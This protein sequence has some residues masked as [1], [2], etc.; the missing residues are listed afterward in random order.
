M[1]KEEQRET[2]SETELEEYD[3]KRLNQKLNLITDVIAAGHRPVV[4][5]TYFVPD[6][7]KAG[8][9]YVA[10]TKEIK[11]IDTVSRTIVSLPQK[12]VEV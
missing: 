12:A 9:E 4:T 2:D 10:V 8:G 7:H 6:Q 1:V 11:K 5:I 3:L